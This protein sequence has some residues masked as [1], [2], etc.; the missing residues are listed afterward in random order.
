[1]FIY[2]KNPDR[3]SWVDLGQGS[4]EQTQLPPRR[5]PPR[6]R[7]VADNGSLLRAARH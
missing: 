3:K 2:E 1:M 4:R 7:L 5:T 6:L